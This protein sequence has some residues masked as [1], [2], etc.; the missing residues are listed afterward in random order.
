VTHQN[1]PGDLRFF[2][3]PAAKKAAAL[4]AGAMLA[5]SA[6]QAEPVFEARPTPRVMAVYAAPALQSLGEDIDA[7][8][9]EQPGVGLVLLAAPAEGALSLRWG[10]P[11]E[12]GGFLAR[13]GEERLVVVAHPENPVER[14]SLEWLR[15]VYLGEETGWPEPG[16]GA[17]DAWGYAAGDDAQRVFEQAILEGGAATSAGLAPNPAALRET[18]A[19]RPGAVGF[20]PARWVDST[21][22]PLAVEGLPGEALRQPVLAQTDAAPNDP[23]RSWL[24]CLQERLR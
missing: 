9:A 12:T 1:R 19:A 23:E 5:T 13:I 14:V 7:C 4:L 22:K 15:G 8:A 3:I 18:V 16:P 24:L 21:V 17:A 10:E 6:C 20:L 11:E 2:K